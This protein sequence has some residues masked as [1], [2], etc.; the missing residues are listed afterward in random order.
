MVS[1]Q[2]GAP[3]AIQIF[4]VIHA[5]QPWC[6]LNT[7]AA[8]LKPESNSSVPV[9]A[10]AL[11]CVL[12]L[13]TCEF[14]DQ[15]VCCTQKSSSAGRISVNLILFC[16]V[17]IMSAA[18]LEVCMPERSGG[19]K[20]M[21]AFA[22]PHDVL[23]HVLFTLKKERHF[24]ENQAPR[25]T[26]PAG[27]HGKKPR[28]PDPLHSCLLL[29]LAVLLQTNVHLRVNFDPQTMPQEDPK[30]IKDALDTLVMKCRDKDFQVRHA[31]FRCLDGVDPALLAKFVSI[32]N[33][34]TVHAM[35]FGVHELAFADPPGL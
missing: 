5:K 15:V 17:V 7:L 14:T 2:T 9:R 34:R 16:Y 1:A 33:W 21:S 10:L 11:T 22:F 25:R 20:G 4:K 12:S 29:L 31:S 24:C 28:P 32:K 26:S 27:C 3:L 6:L 23:Q 19:I 8:L 30:D 35:G 13:Q 18:I